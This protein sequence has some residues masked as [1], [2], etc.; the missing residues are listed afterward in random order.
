MSDTTCDDR[1]SRKRQK[2]FR[3]VTSL[4]G[5]SNADDSVLSD[6]HSLLRTVTVLDL[7][8]V[9]EELKRKKRNDLLRMDTI[10]DLNQDDSSQK[11]CGLMR[12][13]TLITSGYN[14]LRL[15]TEIIRPVASSSSRDVWGTLSSLNPV[16]P[17]IEVKRGISYLFGKKSHRL[18]TISEAQPSELIHFPPDRRFISAFHCKI[19]IDNDEI[20][21]EDE[22]FNGTFINDE[23]IGKRK[24]NVAHAGDIISLYKP[25]EAGEVTQETIH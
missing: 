24:K 1:A 2:L 16:Y 17:S 10:L 21:I 12:L 8:P 3:T 23:K 20:H 22:S 25:Y 19:V 18:K 14:L 6:K 9:D 7:T 13:P 5:I 15:Q 11:I 4:D